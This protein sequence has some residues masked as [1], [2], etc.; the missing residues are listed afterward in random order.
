[1]HLY[2]IRHG[3]SEENTQDY[4]GRNVNSPLTELGQAQAAALGAWVKGRFHFDNLYASPMRRARQTVEPLSEALNIRPTWVDSLREVGN[5]MPNGVA[6]PDDALPSYHVGVWGSRNPYKA[7][8]VDGESWMHFRA[9][10]GSFIE[11]LIQDAP[12]EHRNYHVGV[13]CHGGVIEA[14]FEH[15]FQKGPWSTVV[16][17]T[18]NTG[19][20]YLE[21]FPAQGRPDWWLHYHNQTRHLVEDQIS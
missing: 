12:S 11:G 5:A 16:V 7:I 8:T 10:I 20:S 21:Y 14:V 4:D 2:L 19:I 18:S 17:H 15:V 1:M 6:F 9:R 13:V 3:Q